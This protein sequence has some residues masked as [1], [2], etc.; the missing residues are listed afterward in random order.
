M[1]KAVELQFVPSHCFV[2]GHFISGLWV[3]LD[4]L[5]C[6]ET[7]SCGGPWPPLLQRCRNSWF[8]RWGQNRE[9]DHS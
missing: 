1:V 3:I 6:P 2:A 5:V 7:S 8:S 4:W 9:Q